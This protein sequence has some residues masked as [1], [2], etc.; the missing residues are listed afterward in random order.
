MHGKNKGLAVF[1]KYGGIHVLWTQFI[2]SSV[3]HSLCCK[4]ESKRECYNGKL[5]SAMV[6]SWFWEWPIPA[7][8]PS[9]SLCTWLIWSFVVF[10]FFLFILI[11]IKYAL[12]INVSRKNFL[13]V[14]IHY[15]N[16]FLFLLVRLLEVQFWKC[17]SLLSNIPR[18]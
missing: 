7:Y 16:E 14:P 3:L 11:Q 5:Q 15:H 9:R 8:R 18:S 4:I 2:L 10:F 12:C 6:I 1:G 13:A 17:L